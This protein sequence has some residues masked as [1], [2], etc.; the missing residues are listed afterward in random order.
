MN[1][2]D[3]ALKDIDQQ[4]YKMHNKHIKHRTNVVC[5]ADDC[6]RMNITINGKCCRCNHLAINHDGKCRN[7]LSNSKLNKE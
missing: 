4:L 6:I 5:Y 2:N 3:I 1:S 7:Y